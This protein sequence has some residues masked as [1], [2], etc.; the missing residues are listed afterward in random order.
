MGGAAP[1][2]PRRRTIRHLRDD[3]DL[4]RPLEQP[5][6]PQRRLAHD[7]RRPDRLRGSRQ[8]MLRR[9]RQHRALGNMGILRQMHDH[10]LAADPRGDAVD[11]GRKFVIVMHVGIE[12]A[13]LLHDDFGAAGGQANEIEA[14]TGIERIAQ[15][16]E[17]LAK[18][19][20]DHLAPGHRLPG[21]DHDGANRAI[22]AEETGFQP[23]RALALLRHRRDQHPR[24]TA[25]RSP[26]SPL[27]SRPARRNASPR[28]NPAAACAG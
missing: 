8:M 27:R 19:P 17:P 9:R 26:R 18:Q 23:P 4:F 10:A 20:V 16:L 22:G 28:C 3:L 25:T 1:D 12:I 7:A 15:G 6:R 13:L 5:Q 11:Q 21:I 14:E 2:K 24:Q